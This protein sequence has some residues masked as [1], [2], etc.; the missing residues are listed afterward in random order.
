MIRHQPAR[1]GILIKQARAEPN[2]DDQRQLHHSVGQHRV[3]R[4]Q[5]DNHR[6]QNSGIFGKDGR[7]A[8]HAITYHTRSGISIKTRHFRQINHPTRA[9]GAP[10]SGR[11]QSIPSHSIASC[12]EVSRTAPELVFGQGKRPRSRTL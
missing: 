6:L 10:Q 7:V 4:P 2:G 1:S 12:A 5:G 3:L 9:G 8:R 11:R